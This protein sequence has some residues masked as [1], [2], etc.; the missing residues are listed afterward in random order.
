MNRA[1]QV[2]D[3]AQ[4]HVGPKVLSPLGSL[5]VSLRRREPCRVSHVDGDWVHRYRDGIVV[6]HALGGASARMLDRATWDVFLHRYRPAAGDVVVDLGAGAGD[7]VRLFSRL[8][9]ST[10][11]VVSVEAHPGTFRRLCRTIELNELAN[12]TPMHCAVTDT[13]GVTY[14]EDG[15]PASNSLTDR[16]SG[17]A[18]P[19]DTL[20]GII[21]RSGVT[22][23][24][25]L[26]M[27]IEG[28]ELPVLRAAARILPMVRNLAVSCHDF[29]VGHPGPDPRRTYAETRRLL[30]DA[31]YVVWTRRHDPRPWVRYYLY[32]SRP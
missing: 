27:N 7:E 30:T 32:A 31:G 20:A 14:I 13:A 26:K 18:V 25:L 9:G 3:T 15:L 16:T 11:K 22:R 6:T 10:G 8:V 2:F 29:T 19:G 23:V 1:R 21:E 12:V 5:L 4:R 17:L 28:A 24:G